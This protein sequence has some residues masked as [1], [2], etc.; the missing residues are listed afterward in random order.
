MLTSANDYQ[1]GDFDYIFDMRKMSLDYHVTDKMKE[2]L[3]E[4]GRSPSVLDKFLKLTKK[5]LTT[6]NTVTHVDLKF[7]GKV[8]KLVSSNGTVFLYTFPREMLIELLSR[9]SPEELACVC[10]RYACILQQAQQWAKA[11]KFYDIFVNKYGGT[12]EGFSSPLNS[13]II[14]QSKTAKFCSLFPDVDRP[15][16]SVGSFFD[17]DLVGKVS[18]IH[19]PFVSSLFDRMLEKYKIAYKGV[20]MKTN[21]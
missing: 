16:G 11:N 20:W 17:Q 5:W 13:R 14:L 10:L 21:L 6:K 8:M 12:L 9:G 7:I 15:F 1:D 3:V 18:T 4:K 2:E 19:P